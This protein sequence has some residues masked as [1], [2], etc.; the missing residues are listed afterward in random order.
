MAMPLTHFDGT[1]AAP[2]KKKLVR[3]SDRDYS[4]RLRLASQLSFL[5]LN[6]WIGVQFFFWVRF[7]ESGGSASAV[8]RPAGS[9]PAPHRRPD[10]PEIPIGDGLDAGDP[11][12]KLGSI[13]QY[14][15]DFASAAESLLQLAVPSGNGVR[16][17]VEAWL[18]KPLR[19]FQLPRWAD[20]GLRSLKYLLLGFFGWAVVNMSAVDIDAF[21]RSPYGLIVDVRMLNFFRFLGTTAAV[22]IGIFNDPVAI[23]AEPAVPLPVSIWRAAGHGLARQSREDQALCGSMHRLWQ[24]REG[25]PVS[26]GGRQTGHDPFRRVHWLPRMRRGLPERKTRCSSNCRA[27]HASRRG[28]SRP[29]SPSSLLVELRPQS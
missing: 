4:Q 12:C 1:I 29:P 19:S 8:S 18:E 24:V 9:R 10:E 21:Q 6:V 5:F 14:S 20:L 16:I 15:G 11:S 3:R 23:R 22:A 7:Y 13:G 26:I 25:L 28:L 17:P 2:V 27:R